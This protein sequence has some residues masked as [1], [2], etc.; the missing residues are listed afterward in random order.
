ME[1]SGM[2][3]K[4]LRRRI[5]IL[6]ET[7]KLQRGPTETLH[8]VFVDRNGREQDA[9]IALGPADFICRRLA[10][11]SLEDFKARADAEVLAAKFR[12][13]IA[14]LIFRKEVLDTTA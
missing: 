1:G 5:E 3:H 7:A 8:L 12:V 10:D 6:E 9:D 13:P 14:G 4:D 11:E 2:T